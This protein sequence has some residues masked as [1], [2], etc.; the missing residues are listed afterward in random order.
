MIL[1]EFSFSL[2]HRLPV[3]ILKSLTTWMTATQGK[4]SLMPKKTSAALEPQGEPLQLVIS[5]VFMG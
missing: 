5:G 1:R 2:T 4:P 3:P